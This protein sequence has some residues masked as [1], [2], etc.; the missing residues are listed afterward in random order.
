M[1]DTTGTPDPVD[2]EAAEIDPRSADA[3]E[4]I[5][6]LIDHAEAAGL[7]A[8]LDE[9]PDDPSEVDPPADPAA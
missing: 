7:D 4:Q 2:R 9:L 8:G 1:S 3:P 5:E 6:E